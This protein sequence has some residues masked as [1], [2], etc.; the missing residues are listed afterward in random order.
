MVVEQEPS[1]IAPFTITASN[2][3]LQFTTT[4]APSGTEPSLV[5]LAPSLT[6]PL[7]TTSVATLSIPSSSS[8]T[9]GRD[10][11]RDSGTAGES[12]TIT[13]TISRNRTTT[14]RPTVTVTSLF[15]SVGS[16]TSGASGRQETPRGSVYR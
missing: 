10:E 1:N 5:I 4:V 6:V 9:A 2:S 8:L 14:I 7:V 15:S 12:S 13:I 3:D 16:T 11:T